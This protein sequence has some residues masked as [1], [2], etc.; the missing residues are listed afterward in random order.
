MK[1]KVDNAEPRRGRK[2]GRKDVADDEPHSNQGKARAGDEEEEEEEQAQPKVKHRRTA[3]RT[4]ETAMDE[5]DSKKPRSSAATCQLSMIDEE[6]AIPTPSDA[7]SQHAPTP[8]EMSP[9]TVVTANPQGNMASKQSAAKIAETT[10]DGDAEMIDASTAQDSEKRGFAEDDFVD[11]E[12]EMEVAKLELKIKLIE[13]K[14][15]REEAR[16]KSGA[17]PSRFHGSMNQ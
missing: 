2:R 16:K 1:S 9:T 4:R 14:Q 12:N 17:G 8:T 6:P 15:K 13:A 10:G 11:Y 3:T 7:I 5:V